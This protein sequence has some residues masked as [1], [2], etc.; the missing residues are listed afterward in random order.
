MYNSVFN[1]FFEAEPFAA[2]SIAHGNMYGLSKEFV[3][4]VGAQ[5]G[6]KLEVEGE[7]GDG[8]LS[9]DQLWGSAVSSSSRVGAELW[10]HMYFGHAKN[11]ENAPS[12]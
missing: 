10:P 5:E 9:R 6:P 4:G 1:L 11:P 2:I 12:E 7:I 3:L 8:V